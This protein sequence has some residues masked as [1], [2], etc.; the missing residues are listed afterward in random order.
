MTRLAGLLLAGGQSRRMGGGDKC[1]LPFRGQTVLDHVIGRMRPQLP[2]LALNANGD[3]ARF[4]A[5]GLPVLP[6]SLPGNLGPLAGVLTGLEWAAAQGG[7]DSLV[8]VP[9]DA[10]FL[11]ADLAQRLLAARDREGADMATASSQGR[12]HPVIGLWPV[13]A[14]GDL[15]R[16]LLRDGVRKVDAWTARYRLA[17]A[18]Y[19]GQPDPFFNLNRPEDLARAAGLADGKPGQTASRAVPGCPGPA[20]PAP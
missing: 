6:D 20:N 4:R 1:L 2:L 10:P 18:D 14:A 8:T 16:A 7:I 13:S 3:P 15:R 19:T 11:P 12:T 17:V 5:C 9:T